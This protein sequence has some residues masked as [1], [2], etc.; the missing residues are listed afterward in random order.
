MLS[1]RLLERV[2]PFLSDLGVFAPWRSI[3]LERSNAMRIRIPCDSISTR[4]DHRFGPPRAR[5]SCVQP[6][7]F[8]IARNHPWAHGISAHRACRAEPKML[9]EPA[10]YLGYTADLMQRLLILALVIGVGCATTG[11]D[12]S[13][14]DE[15]GVGSTQYL[16][17]L[18]FSGTNVD[19]WIGVR[20][21]L[22]REFNNLCGDTFCGGDYSNLTPLRLTC[23]VSSKAGKIKDCAWTFAGSLASVGSKT[24]A[25][26]VDAPTFECHIQPKTTVAHLVTLLSGSTD[27]IHLALPGTTSIYD[28]LGECFQHP[29][30]K[31]PVTFDND[32]APIY[33]DATDYYQTFAGQQKWRAAKA[34][35]VAGFDRV[36]GDTFC[37]SDFSDLRSLDLVCAITK[38]SGNVKSC[39][40]VF[41][42][43]YSLVGEKS[44]VLAETS[45]SFR[46]NVPVKGTL[47]QLIATLTKTD[48]VDAI[49]RPL[50]GGAATAYDALGGCLP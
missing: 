47:G 35:L 24:A 17:I 15:Q 1:V 9:L 39:A 20:L 7:V 3:P 40:W 14:V 29:I 12:P 5:M 10:F 36:C 50:P 27:A 21:E 11:D 19:A 2:F 6:Y 34:A 31:T 49:R 28:A 46:C 18:D 32:P 13:Q 42:G 16:D 33:I 30:G 43:S 4:S 44:G 26:A 37:S 38:S 45:K 25:I 23:A 22:D 48:P 8:C 41:G